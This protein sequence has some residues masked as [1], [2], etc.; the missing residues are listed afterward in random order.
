[1]FENLQEWF[2]KNTP[3][4]DLIYKNGLWTQV[5]IVRD[6]IPSIL[7]RSYEE[8]IGVRQ[9]LHVISTHRSKSVLL[10]VFELN[11]NGYRFIMR[12]NFYDWKVSVRT[13]V[14]DL[15][16]IDADFMNLFKLDERI[17]LVYCEGFKE[18]WVYGPYSEDKR[19]FTCE[20]SD[21]S[22]LFTF[23]WILKYNVSK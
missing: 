3:G 20:I 1:M 2:E 8:Y 13:P 5:Q 4:E 9:Q 14:R 23:F 22:K 17:N 18:D 11:W 15:A 21:N 7:A 19:K 6:V 12:Y 10:P 16:G